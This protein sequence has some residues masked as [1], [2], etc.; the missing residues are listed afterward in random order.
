MVSAYTSIA[1]A[2]YKDLRSCVNASHIPFPPWGNQH[3]P[4]DSG[5]PGPPGKNDTRYESDP[6]LSIKYQKLTPFQT[7]PGDPGADGRDGV[8]GADGR[9][10][11]PGADGRD[12][13]P[14][15]EGMYATCPLKSSIQN[16]Q[17]CE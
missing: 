7:L 6:P 9:D 13:D 3:P 4:P 14:G 17:L 5:P 15:P 2:M 11:D 16:E 10:G 12:G 8:P 1:F